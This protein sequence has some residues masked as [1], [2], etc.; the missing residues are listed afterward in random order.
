MAKGF[1]GNYFSLNAIVATVSIIKI[2]SINNSLVNKKIAFN[3]TTS[4][5]SP[6]NN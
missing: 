2:R 5:I 3:Y 4:G 1:K 6:P